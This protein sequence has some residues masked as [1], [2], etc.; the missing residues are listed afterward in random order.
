MIDANLLFA[1]FTSVLV[2]NTAYEDGPVA[3]NLGVGLPLTIPMH[4]LVYVTNSS[5][6]VFEFKFEVTVDNGTT[7]RSI[8]MV[9]VPA[10]RTGIYSAPVNSDLVP[11]LFATGDIDIRVRYISASA[12]GVDD[13]TARCALGTREHSMRQ[14][15]P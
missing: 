2:I 6:R 5:D 14:Y 11:E 8:G 15:N 3:L 7:W 9:E 10:S 4:L 13:I 1:A 12:A